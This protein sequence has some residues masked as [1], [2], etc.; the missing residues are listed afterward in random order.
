MKKFPLFF[1][2]AVVAVMLAIAAAPGSA[3]AAFA[4]DLSVAPLTVL[5]GPSP[6]A[7]NCDGVQPRGQVYLNAEAEPIVAAN[8]TN[9]QNVVAAWQQDRWSNGGARG[10]LASVTHDGGQSWSRTAAPFTRCTGGTTANGGDHSRASDP[11][12]SFAPNGDVYQ[13]AL[14]ID[15]RTYQGFSYQAANILVS[16][17]SDGGDTWSTAIALTH[18]T[19]I[20]VFNDK[21]SITADL[22]D[23]RYVYAVWDRIEVPAGTADY[24]I[25]PALQGLAHQQIHV[26]LQ[27][28]LF[29]RTTNAGANWE[30][31]R[32]IYD[33][34]ERN[35]TIGSEIVVLPNGTLVNMFEGYFASNYQGLSGYNQMVI[36]STDRGATW[37][38]AI[39]VSPDLAVGM[40]DP[41][42]GL[43]IRTNNDLPHVTVDRQSGA[44]Y[45]VWGDSRFSGGQRDG[46]VLVKSTNG[47]LTWS[48]PVQIN[49]EPGAPAFTPTISVAADGTVAVS[50]YDLRNDTSDP[51][52]LLADYWIIHSHDGGA[53]WSEEHISGPFDIKTAPI[54][55]GYFL[56]DYQ[57]LTSAKNTFLSV[58]VQANS[59]NTANRNDVFFTTITP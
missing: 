2:M 46:I 8:P 31:A 58:F 54:A 45:A 33:P 19:L 35:A 51:D 12:V 50:Y 1:A 9:P 48:G 42:T 27:P 38:A 25:R 26:G 56:G 28:I 30:P 57:G 14:A 53:T 13:S 32:V 15:W 11:W 5:S 39:P 49:Q 16:K 43:P 47:G 3:L 21:E 52:T 44:L 37:S 41:A 59:G 29:S 34:G 40:V 55:G 4:D 23:A 10:L 22:T 17:S 18:D 7:P 36:R 6:F 20:T 24:E